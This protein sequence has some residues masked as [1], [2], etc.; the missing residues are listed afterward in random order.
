MR[1]GQTETVGLVII[2]ILLI[3]IAIFALSFSIKPKQEND[4]ILKL[5]ANALRASVLK[6][7]LC[8]SVSV[9]DELENC[10][11]GYNECIDCGELSSEVVNIIKN[12]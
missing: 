12:S 1:K 2:V 3:F 4:D 11:D 6:T 10:I 5:K 8:G 9:K 7:N